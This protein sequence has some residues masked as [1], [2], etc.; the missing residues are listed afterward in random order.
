MRKL[1]E[2]IELIKGSVEIIKTI[3]IVGLF[4]SSFFGAKSCQD[5]KERYRQAESIITE[6]ERLFSNEMGQKASEVHTIKVKYDQLRRSS[7]QTEMEKTEYQK[8]LADAYKNIEMY[9]RK[10]KDLVS[11]GSYTLRA[12]DTVR[13]LQP[14]PCDQLVPIN[15]KHIDL[16][17]LYNEDNNLSGIIYDYRTNVNTLVTLYPKR[18]DNGK[19]HFPNWGFIWGWDKVSITTVEDTCASISNQVSI[20][21]K[22]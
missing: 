9:K 3:A 14:I 5:M 21:F 22:K 15:T 6:K 11:Y 16:F 19:K 1:R 7:E 12:R 2:I 8:K 17:F 18:K 4:V 20:E 10:D 13:L